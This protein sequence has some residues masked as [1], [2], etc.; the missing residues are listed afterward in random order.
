MSNLFDTDNFLGSSAGG[1]LSTERTLIPIGTYPDC[2]VSDL[3]LNHGT[4]ENG[5]KAGDKWARLNIIYEI[6]DD[7]VR[8]ELDRAKVLVSG[9]IFLDITPEGALDNGRGKNVRLGKLKAALGL[10]GANDTWQDFLGKR[11]VLT[12]GHGVNKKDGS[13]TEEVLGVA[14][15]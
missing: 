1:V 11:V 5:E 10:N 8:N 12:I 13:A 4:Y 2:T 14:G 15:Q 7:A 9:G 6:H 3:K